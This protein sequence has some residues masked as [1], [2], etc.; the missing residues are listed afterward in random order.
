MGRQRRHTRDL[1]RLVVGTVVFADEGEAPWR[2]CN[3][4][5]VLIWCLSR[6][7]TEFTARIPGH[8]LFPSVAMQQ[9]FMSSAI[10]QRL[11]VC[12]GVRLVPAAAGGVCLCPPACL[13]VCLSARLPLGIGISVIGILPVHCDR[14]P[15]NLSC[16]PPA[17]SASLCRDVSPHRLTAHLTV[18]P[19]TSP[20]RSPRHR[21][22]YK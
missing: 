18:S 9:A 10:R 19:L 2:P 20:G 12:I 15:V 6:R 22:P 4:W 5:V 21:E 3:V 7:P 13:P 17:A 11:A 14:P 1:W 16:R 8:K